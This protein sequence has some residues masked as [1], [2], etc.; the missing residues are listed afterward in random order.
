MVMKEDLKA[1]RVNEATY[2]LMTISEHDR[3]MV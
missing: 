2:V 1:V 3:G